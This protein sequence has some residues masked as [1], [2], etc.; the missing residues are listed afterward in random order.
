MGRGIAMTIE[1]IN[2]NHN[3][4]NFQIKDMCLRIKEGELIGIVGNNGSGKTTLLKIISGIL[5]NDNVYIDG[6]KIK[7]KDFSIISYMDSSPFFYELLKVN[8]KIDLLKTIYG[9]QYEKRVDLWIEELGLKQYENELIKNLSLGNRQKLAII[10]SLINKPRFILLDEPFNGID[11][12][13]VKK[14]TDILCCLVKEQRTIVL[15]THINNMLDKLCTR[16]ITLHEG[17]IINDSLM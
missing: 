16:L 5:K 1:L 3:Y 13:S 2:V 15:T 10:M 17:K 4:E 12:A 14:I 7:P 9:N 8:E 11:K 6:E